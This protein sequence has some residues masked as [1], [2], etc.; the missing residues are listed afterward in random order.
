M[1]DRE[2]LLDHPESRNERRG[3]KVWFYYNSRHVHSRAASMALLA[4]LAVWFAPMVAWT[5]DVGGALAMAFGLLVF[6]AI[7]WGHLLATCII[8]GPFVIDLDARELRR[9]WP[10]ARWPLSMVKLRAKPSAV[11]FDGVQPRW[12]AAM[13]PDGFEHYLGRA[14]APEVERVIARL[15]A[16]QDDARAE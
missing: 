6:S 15:K 5:Q 14:E 7:A 8:F 9:S 11:F 10:A 2:L 16:F 1:D 4:G 12:V 13:T 3:R